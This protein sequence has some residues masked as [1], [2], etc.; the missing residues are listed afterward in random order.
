MANS[1]LVSRSE[2]YKRLTHH[3]FAAGLG[4]VAHSGPPELPPIARGTKNCAPPNGTAD[5]SLHVMRPPN[6]HPPI[7]MR[8][9]QAEQ[10][11]ASL[12]PE[13]GN[14]LAWPGSYLMRAGWAYGEP[15]RAADPAEA[16]QR[17]TKTRRK[18]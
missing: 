8:W 13:K 16:A 18:G 1:P 10:A 12:Q 15:V 7:T 5:G 11:W 3:Q 4:Y 2:A 6:G 14:R 9:V 17:T